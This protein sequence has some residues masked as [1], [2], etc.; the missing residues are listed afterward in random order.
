M[1]KVLVNLGSCKCLNLL[2]FSHLLSNKQNCNFK[3]WLLCIYI[4]FLGDAS[5]A[6]DMVKHVNLFLKLLKLV[7]LNGEKSNLSV[8]LQPVFACQMGK[9]IP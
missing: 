9:S 5:N 7:F 1:Q 6:A 2:G 4:W 8:V 3:I